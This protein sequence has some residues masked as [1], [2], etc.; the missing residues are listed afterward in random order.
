MKYLG[1]FYPDQCPL[2]DIDIEIQRKLANSIGSGY[3]GIHQ[4][5]QAMSTRRDEWTMNQLADTRGGKCSCRRD[6]YHRL[7]PPARACV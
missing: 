6:Y 5:E 3:Y 7:I 1:Y 2:T 4:T